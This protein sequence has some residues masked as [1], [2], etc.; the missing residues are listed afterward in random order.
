MAYSGS[1]IST[2]RINEDVNRLKDNYGKIFGE[3][4]LIRELEK[5][6]NEKKCLEK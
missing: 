3:S 5:R 2:G 4:P 1:A 6:E